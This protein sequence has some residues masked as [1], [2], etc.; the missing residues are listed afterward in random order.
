MTPWRNL[1][2]PWCRHGRESCEGLL[3]PPY[4]TL[5]RVHCRC[6]AHKDAARVGGELCWL[7]PSAPAAHP[8]FTTDAAGRNPC[9]SH[10]CPAP[11]R[12][13]PQHAEGQAA[14]LN[15]LAVLQVGRRVSSLLEQEIAL[16]GFMAVGAG[17]CTDHGDFRGEL[18]PA[19]TL[20]TCAQHDASRRWS[21]GR[22]HADRAAAWVALRTVLCLMKQKGVLEGLLTLACLPLTCSYYACSWKARPASS[23]MVGGTAG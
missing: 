9:C 20:Q 1:S 15:V 11:S 7:L 17:V 16:P 13:Q 22:R 8:A 18:C 3:R 23:G 14:A 12:A 21:S 2:S 10:A 5:N 4:L 6:P 19:G